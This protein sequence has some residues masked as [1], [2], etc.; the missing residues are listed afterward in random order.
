M[1]LPLPPPPAQVPV[2][3]SVPAPASRASADLPLLPGSDPRVLGAYRWTLAHSPSLRQLVRQLAAAERKARYRLVPGLEPNYGRL[4]VLPTASEYEVDVQVPILAWNRCG[5]ALEPWI[6]SA[7]YLA[8]ETAAKGK[9]RATRDEHRLL[10]LKET[11]QGAFAFQAQVRRELALADPVR[12]KDLPDGKKLYDSGFAPARDPSGSPRRRELPA[13]ASAGAF[14]GVPFAVPPPPPPAEAGGLP[15]APGSDPQILGAYRWAVAH[16][17]SLQ[18]A[19]QRLTAADRKARYRLTPGLDA[20]YG[21]LRVQATDEEY[22]V[23][24]QVPILPWSRCGDALEPWIASALYLALET[25]AKGK[26]Q[27]T[28]DEHRLRF[29]RETRNAAFTFQAQVRRELVLADPERLKDLP[30][31]ERLY[32]SGFAPA[33]DPSGSPARRALP[34]RPPQPPETPAPR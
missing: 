32:D 9:F 5:D 16:S 26:V 3:A 22:E 6:A 18:A 8:L 31:G 4:L 19:I 28:D 21:R 11:M 2:Q 13:E 14:G 20:H 23:E 34:P 29:L 33:R 10:F 24:V 12:L 17:P 7:L 25:A 15:L 1:F 27:E 30:N